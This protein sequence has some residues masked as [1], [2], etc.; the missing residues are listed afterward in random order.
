MR[1]I[2]K[3]ENKVLI[4]I[5]LKTKEQKINKNTI[6]LIYFLF[7]LFLIF[8]QFLLNIHLL[9]SISNLK[10]EI[11]I[12]KR[13]YKEFRFE[14]SNFVHNKDIQNKIKILNKSYNYLKKNIYI[15]SS[16]INVTKL[17]CFYEIRSKFLKK[18][19]TPYTDNKI[20]LFSDYVNWLIIHDTNY[21]KG[22]AADKINC[23]KNYITKKL[24]QDICKKIIKVY[25]NPDNINI[26]ELPEKFVIKA[27]HGCGMNIIVE[28]KKEFDLEKAKK[29][30]VLG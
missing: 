11:K 28:D 17:H 23:C 19:K 15:L 12:I 1:I 18:I 10:K 13:K 24:G 9:D 20:I 4:P 14:N 26:N 29:Y 8:I 3:D 16:E 21:L 30:Y 22:L 7:I 5:K 27:N 6:L 25:D 2:G